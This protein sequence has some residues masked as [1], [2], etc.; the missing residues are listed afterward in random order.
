MVKSEFIKMDYV[1]LYKFELRTCHH[2]ELIKDKVSTSQLL[3][4]GL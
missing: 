1:I 3:M 2:S 4:I